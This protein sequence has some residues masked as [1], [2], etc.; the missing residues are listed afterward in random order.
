MQK[1]QAK[2]EGGVTNQELDRETGT[3]AEGEPKAPETGKTDIEQLNKRLS[4]MSAVV[5]I[6]GALDRK[7][8]VGWNEKTQAVTIADDERALEEKEVYD[9][10]LQKR[11][12][13]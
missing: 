2:L 5:K 9:F 10:L 6:C 7:D 4:E 12:T 11:Q 1:E 8:V 13:M 3:V